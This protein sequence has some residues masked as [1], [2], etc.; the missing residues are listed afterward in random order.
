MRIIRLDDSMTKVELSKRMNIS[1]TLIN[2]YENGKVNP[3]LE[4]I[5]KFNSLF[6][7]S[8]EYVKTV[9]RV[10]EGFRRKV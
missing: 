9:K 3:S 6:N 4:Y 8:F 1:E 10:T 2:N 7:V 5:T